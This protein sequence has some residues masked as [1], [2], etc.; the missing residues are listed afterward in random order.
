MIKKVCLLL[1]LCLG[2]GAQ[3][4]EPGPVLATAVPVLHALGQSLMQ[5]TGVEVAYLPPRRLP[6]NR[7]PGWLGKADAA[8][9][10]DATAL[11]TIESVWPALSAYPLLRQRNIAVIPVDVAQELAPQGA[12]VSLRP[13]L[14]EPD[15]FWLD[16]N[17]LL[18]MTNVAARDL[19]RIWPEQAG[20]IETNRRA[21][22]R[23]IQRQSLAM[24]ELLFNANIGALATDDERLVPL[25]MGL[26]LPQVSSERADLRLGA[27]KGSSEPGLWRLTPLARPG[28]GDLTAWLSELTAGL[29]HTLTA[30]P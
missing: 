16:T 8:S 14:S 15:Y 10:P 2:P 22:Q 4:A 27:G 18:L 7:I 17:N 23:H 13:N 25:V 11:L 9:L 29:E 30:T 26:A 24:D 21:L 6:V 1:L 19:A 20:K 12:Q 28:K 5:N 3:A